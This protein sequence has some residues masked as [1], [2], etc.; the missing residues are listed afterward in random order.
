MHNQAQQASKESIPPAFVTRTRIFKPFKEPRNRFPSW[1]SG[2][3]TLFVGP[4]RQTTYAGG[5]DFSE[6]IPGLHKRLQIRALG[7]AGI[8]QIGCRTSH[9]QA[10]HWLAKSIPWNR[11]LGSSKVYKFG[12]WYTF[13]IL[14]LVLFI[15]SCFLL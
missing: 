3:T 12:Q 6:S 10:I 5:I 11:F 8:R 1:R 9:P 4:A 15:I 13:Y 7:R 14:Y 2:T